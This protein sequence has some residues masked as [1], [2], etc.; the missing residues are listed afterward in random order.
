M[1]DNQVPAFQL[2]LV[3]EE[4]LKFAASYGYKDL[5]TREPVLPTHWFQPGSIAKTFMATTIFR[6]AELGV[7]RVN[8]TVFGPGGILGERYG[9]PPYGPNV[10]GIQVRHL[11]EHTGGWGRPPD[12]FEVFPHM[13]DQEFMDEFI[14]Q[15]PPTGAPDTFWA[16][17]NFNYRLLQEVIETL[18]GAPFQVI[19][20]RAVSSS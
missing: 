14:R 9:D 6:L 12:I 3:V 19:G 10:T 20:R 2:A 8:Q 11:L 7:L 13:E 16:Y 15:V 18:T 1:R 4:E 5:L 17:S